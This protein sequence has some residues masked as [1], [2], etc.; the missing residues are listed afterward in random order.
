MF[1]PKTVARILQTSAPTLLTALA[2]PPPFNLIASTI[3]SAAIA[4]L[5]RDA[6]EEPEQAEDAAAAEGAAPA[7]ATK[8]TPME[9]VETVEKNSDDPRLIPALKQAENDL[10]KYEMDNNLRFAELELADKKRAGDFQIKSDL[11]K[12]I[13][14]AGTTFVVIAML[15]VILLIITMM[16]IMTGNI[17]IHADPN[18]SIA[19]FGLI[20]TSIGFISGIA[21]AVVTFYF[22]SSQG[23]KDKSQ[24][25]ENSMQEF[26]QSLKD[27]TDVA[28][29]NRYNKPK[30]KPKP[31][32]PGGG[33]AGADVAPGATEERGASVVPASPHLTREVLAQLIKPHRKFPESVNWK[34]TADGISIEGAEAERTAG[35]PTTVT[36]IWEQYGEAC[37]YWAKEYGVP[38]ELIV[39]TIA[40]E[41]RG[42]PNAERE[43]PHLNTKSVGLMQTLIT[44]ARSTLK[45][46]GLSDK[47][48][49]R[50]S[51]SI[52][53]GTAYIAS[54]RGETHFDP[55][56]V[57]AAYN[58][59]SVRSDAA[60]TNR[61]R[62][63]CYPKGTG[64]HVDHFVSW[65]GD[66][67]AVSTE[68]DWGKGGSVPSFASAF[69]SVTGQEGAGNT[70]LAAVA[71]AAGASAVS[72]LKGIAARNLP[73][74]EVGGNKGLVT[75]LQNRLNL[76]GYL[77][78]PAD[79]KFGPISSWA[80]NSFRGLNQIPDTDT[81]SDAL[82][83]AILED[84]R[85][86]P[87]LP[88]SGDWYDKVIAYMEKNGLWICK[89]P[90]C[91]NIVYLEGVDETGALNPDDP[92]KFNDLRTVFWTD[93]TKLHWQAWDATTEPGTYFTNNPLNPKGAAR[94]KFGQYAAWRVGMHRGDHEALVQVREVPVH[95]DLNKDHSRAGDTVYTGLFGINQHKGY[96]NAP[97][98]IGKASAGC[99]VGRT[100]KGHEEFMRELKK[101]PR[102]RAT[103]GYTFMTTILP[104]AKVL[105]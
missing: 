39:A 68:Q 48:L 38:V 89:Y 105:S 77:D 80:L 36:R 13:F 23:S 34:L 6:D 60:S 63:H 65:F 40:T 4:A 85:T 76:L 32:A 21:S 12:H 29:S 74:E 95:R 57:A 19:A 55:P 66:A 9:I 70:V 15:G 103:P 75:A 99:L 47:D 14:Y 90:E 16:R 62:L 71:A 31:G 1:I 3:A 8:L 37:T 20:G 97:N 54:Q 46:P 28:A 88:S 67:M 5:T 42:E 7:A 22:G 26:S 78:P 81:L 86:L 50:P 43:E 87:T 83:A 59:G 84:T 56:L 24:T 93:G 18:L 11:S 72:L 10:K 69:A 45:R 101:D 79:G 2:V 102:Y 33:G 35:K 100:N 44:T 94:I 64:R 58:A 41:S 82:V 52:E 104:A 53:A 92:N 96:N 25:I 49:R 61:W 51:T 30:P 98:A 91:R 17:E 27:A 73:L